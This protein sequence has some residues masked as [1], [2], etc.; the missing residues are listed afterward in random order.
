[1]AAAA[2]RKVATR[3][4][5]LV[6]EVGLR[7]FPGRAGKAERER[8]RWLVVT[9]EGHPAQ[10]TGEGQ[11]PAPLAEFGD[12]VEVEVRPGPGG[13]GTEIAARPASTR[14]SPVADRQMRERLRSALRQT[15][16]LLEVGE[17]LVA[18]P[19]PE[20][21]RPATVAGKLVDHAVRTANEKGVL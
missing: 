3:A 21:R 7:L 11:L 5:D 17:V 4:Q 19:R 6:G 1:M 10:I 2:A 14:S 20:G 13:W 18:E 12:S 15:K 8:Q 9:V 16:Q